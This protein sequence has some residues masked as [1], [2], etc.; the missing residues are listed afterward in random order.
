MYMKLKAEK[1]YMTIQSIYK[2]GNF[3]NI[4]DPVRMKNALPSGPK[5]SYSK[6]PTGPTEFG[7][8]D[9][10]SVLVLPAI[11]KGDGVNFLGIKP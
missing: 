1:L 11:V 3:I 6:N 7:F 2:R 4:F 9:N 8:M 5:I 10:L